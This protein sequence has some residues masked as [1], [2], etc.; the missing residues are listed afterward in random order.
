MTDSIDGTSWVQKVEQKYGPHGANSLSDPDGGLRVV[1]NTC[2]IQGYNLTNLKGHLDVLGVANS[3]GFWG[4]VSP[5]FQ[6]TRIRNVS[7][8]NLVVKNAAGEDVSLGSFPNALLDGSSICP[9]MVETG[10]ASTV[11]VPVTI[12]ADAAYQLYDVEADGGDRTATNGEM[13]VWF[14]RKQV[15]WRGTITNAAGGDYTAWGTMTP[16]D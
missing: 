5:E 11:G 7:F 14:P 16:A 1:I 3:L 4:V 9:W 10:G 8:S 13:Q 12:T 15:S 2:D 6:S